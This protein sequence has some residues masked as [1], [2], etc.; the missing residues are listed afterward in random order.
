MGAEGLCRQGPTVTC[1]SQRTWCSLRPSSKSCKTQEGAWAETRGDPPAPHALRGRS[2]D[3][4][5]RVLTRGSACLETHA[6]LYLLKLPQN[7]LVPMQ[8][9]GILPPEGKQGLAPTA[10]SPPGFLPPARTR[11]AA[12]Q[13]GTLAPPSPHGPGF[14]G[15]LGEPQ[16]VPSCPGTARHLVLARRGTVPPH[17]S[18]PVCHQDGDASPLPA[19]GWAVPPS[20]GTP[21]PRSGGVEIRGCHHPVGDAG[22]GGSG[23]GSRRQG[24]EGR[25]EGWGQRGGC[26]GQQVGQGTAH[27][28]WSIMPGGSTRVQSPGTYQTGAVWCSLQ[29]ER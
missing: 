26:D 20:A 13:H 15:E 29:K 5:S 19:L 14:H 27:S 28:H 12:L 4:S 11:L 17:Q 24:S 18:H 8:G 7:R 16:R 9:G 10:G 21:H 6:C 25:G 2:P 3:A 23:L 22:D 1:W